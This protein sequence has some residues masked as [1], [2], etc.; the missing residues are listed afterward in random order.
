[1]AALVVEGLLTID[2]R[3]PAVLDQVML[4]RLSRR[5]EPSCAPIWAEPTE[6]SREAGWR[7]ASRPTFLTAQLKDD[8]FNNA[9]RFLRLEPK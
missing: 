9:A 8:I 7:R 3:T 1:M 5:K 4:Y 6:R 2:P